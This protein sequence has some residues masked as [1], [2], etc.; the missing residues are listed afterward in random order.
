MVGTQH[1][2]LE[3][4]LQRRPRTDPSLDDDMG[5]L[6]I[7]TL[8]EESSHVDPVTFYR[9]SV[10]PLRYAPYPPSI[11][12][13]APVTYDAEAST[14]LIAECVARA[15]LAAQQGIVFMSRTGMDEAT[16][17]ATACSLTEQLLPTSIKNVTPSSI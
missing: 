9:F 15:L 14:A 7:S 5:S 2:G 8:T 3:F 13:T 11:L 4:R 16:L 10:I 12:N 17:I 6:Q 1:A